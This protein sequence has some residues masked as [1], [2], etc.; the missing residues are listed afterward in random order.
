MRILP[1]FL[2]FLPITVF[3]MKGLN[4]LAV[5]ALSFN[6]SKLTAEYLKDRGVVVEFDSPETKLHAKTILVDGKATII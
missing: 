3:L 5:G 4:L 2:K 6:N 1:G